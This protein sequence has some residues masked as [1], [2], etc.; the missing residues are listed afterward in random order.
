[1]MDIFLLSFVG[2]KKPKIGFDYGKNYG[3][4]FSS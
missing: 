2:T 3:L 1:M 4:L